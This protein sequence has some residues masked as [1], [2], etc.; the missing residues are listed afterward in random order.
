M[1]ILLRVFNIDTGK[2]FSSWLILHRLGIF[3]RQNDCTCKE[4][5]TRHAMW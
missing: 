4:H 5:S 3:G 1:K 2:Y